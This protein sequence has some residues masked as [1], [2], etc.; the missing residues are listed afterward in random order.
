VQG[1]TS[2]RFVFVFDTAQKKAVRTAISLTGN[3]EDVA[4]VT[5]GL[6]EGDTVITDGLMRLT[7]GAN[8]EVATPAPEKSAA[9]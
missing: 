3:Y 1:D 2:Q 4:V 9:P 8:V 7:D 5:S 6:Q